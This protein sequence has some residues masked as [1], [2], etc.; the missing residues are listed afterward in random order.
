MYL[1]K[2]EMAIGWKETVIWGEVGLRS[3][4]C[5]R[6]SS[7]CHGAKRDLYLP[8]KDGSR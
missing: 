2:I 5:G 7:V 1:S 4:G 8:S 3:G 6:S